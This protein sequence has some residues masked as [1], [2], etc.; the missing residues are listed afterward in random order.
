MLFVF[1]QDRLI[2]VHA[3]PKQVPR[4]SVCCVVRGCIIDYDQP[5][6]R[7]RLLQDRLQVPGVAKILDVVVG[8][9]HDAGVQLLG[10]L[11]GFICLL[12]VQLLLLGNLSHLVAVGDLLAKQKLILKAL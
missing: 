9:D 10:S 1:Y 7:V 6:V 3:P 4:D 8:W 11:V 12:V 5:I 2:L